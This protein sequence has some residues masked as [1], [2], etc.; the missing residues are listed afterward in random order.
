MNNLIQMLLANKMNQIPNTMMKQLENQLKRANPQAFQEFQKARKNNEN[1][2]EYL[3][4]VVNGFS[5][6]Q[7]DQWNTMMSGY[8]IN[9]K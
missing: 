5:Q 4:K 9:I 7:K 3:N 8:G 6:E 2:N 1:P